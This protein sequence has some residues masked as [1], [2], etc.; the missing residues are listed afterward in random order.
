MNVLK[1][2]F[3]YLLCSFKLSYYLYAFG[4]LIMCFPM[5]WQTLKMSALH[6]AL[7]EENLYYCN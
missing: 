3:T 7:D 4:E 6:L 5:V 1:H 2:I